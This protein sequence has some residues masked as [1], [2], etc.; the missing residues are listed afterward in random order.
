MAWRDDPDEFSVLAM[1]E[2]SGD[3]SVDSTIVELDHWSAP[4]AADLRAQREARDRLARD[5][6]SPAGRAAQAA[7]EAD[8]AASAEASRRWVAAHAAAGCTECQALRDQS[9]CGKEN[10]EG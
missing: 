8:M 6:R 7:Y 1:P 10:S 5:M 3:P 2:A 4:R 9:L